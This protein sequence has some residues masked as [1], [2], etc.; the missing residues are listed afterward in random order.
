[1][2]NGFIDTARF[3]GLSMIILA[4]V[5][6]P[7]IIFQLRNFD[8]P[9]MVLISAFPFTLAS[10]KVNNYGS[11]LYKRFKRLI[12][13]VWIFLTLY[14]SALFV[15]Q[16][17]SQILSLYTIATSFALISGIGY[18][19]II[20]VFFLVA[21]MTPLLLAINKKV[22]NNT[23]YFVF[24]SMLFIA[25]EFYVSNF[26]IENMGVAG[27]L[28]SMVINF[29]IPYSLVFMIGL[30]L[31]ILSLSQT[32]MLGTICL[33]IFVSICFYLYFV[34][35][36]VVPTQVFK[37]PPRLY[38]FSYAIG[39][40][41]LVWSFIVP[42]E[43]GFSL[44]KLKNISSFIGQNSIWTYLWHIPF[45]QVIEGPFLLKYVLVYMASVVLTYIQVTLVHHWLMPRIYNVR[46]S[47]T[48]K[49]LLTG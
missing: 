49:T 28:L 35:G 20:R 10:T 23:S 4:H 44:L 9:F 43:K 32:R 33:T 26:N 16:P 19:W 27:N 36:S 21:L 14:F 18:V 34:N 29:I 45:V 47:K 11:Y 39:V 48:V 2:R 8:L 12:L 3:I 6:P 42:I 15:F 22:T 25:F 40:G 24:I 46:L 7:D 17:D 30:R 37:Y 38:Y 13:P 1:M 31:P 41:A 5:D